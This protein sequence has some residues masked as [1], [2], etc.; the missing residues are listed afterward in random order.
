M[1][2]VLIHDAI[3]EIANEFPFLW[4]SDWRPKITSF[5][6]RKV[7]DVI[8]DEMKVIPFWIIIMLDFKKVSSHIS[9]RMFIAISGNCVKRLMQIS[10][11]MD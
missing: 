1:V 10:N 2:G 4:S 9:V 5:V 8:P 3:S 11:K 7:E 6:V